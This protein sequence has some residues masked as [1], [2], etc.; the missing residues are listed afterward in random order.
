MKVYQLKITLRYTKPP[1]WR[2]VLVPGNITLK[3]LH[4]IIQVVM[5]WE[6]YHLHAFEIGKK[7]Y[8]PISPNDLYED[9]LD[10]SKFT[11]DKLRKGQKF[12]YEYDFGDSWKHDIVVEKILP[13]DAAKELPKCIGGKRACP[14]EDVGG[15]MGYQELLFAL[16]NK[17]SEEYKEYVEWLGY[18]YDPDRFDIEA[19]NKRL[20]VIKLD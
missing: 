20:K 18:E 9:R 15:V 2:R 11:L 5:G 14:P 1:V 3:T 17:E 7:S 16:E 12:L 10:E 19:V 4:Q 13:P 6:D 8:G